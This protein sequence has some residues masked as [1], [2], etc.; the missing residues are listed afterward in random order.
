MSGT[1]TNTNPKVKQFTFGVSSIWTVQMYPLSMADYNDVLN[2]IIGTISVACNGDW[3]KLDNLSQTEIILLAKN[4][5]GDNLHEIAKK[6]FRKQDVPKNPEEEIDTS[7]FLVFVD[8]LWHQNFEKSLKKNGKA[9]Y[10][11]I[12]TSLVPKRPSTS[13]SQDTPG[14]A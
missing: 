6:V 12:K 5:A 7:Q 8:N 2:G 14:I 10:E 4:L 1:K 3:Q 11:K 9:L 13:S